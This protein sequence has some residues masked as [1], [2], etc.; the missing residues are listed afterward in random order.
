MAGMTDKSGHKA[1][2]TAVVAALHRELGIPASYAIERNLVAHDE[3]R[4]A[5]LVEVGLNPDGRPVRLT[6]RAVEAWSRMRD[7]ATADGIQL[8]PISGFRPVARQAE[9]IREKRAAGQSLEDILRYVAAPGFSEHTPAARSTS[10]RPSTSSWTKISNTRQRSSG[11][12]S[13]RAN[14][15]SRFPIRAAMRT[16]LATSHG[17]GAGAARAP[18]ADLAP[19]KVCRA[20]LAAYLE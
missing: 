16:A 17:T 8:V 20:S 13:T 7:A 2:P 11:S 10:A 3:A 15:A 5:D 18:A 6:A 19:R 14:S 1:P 12:R 4:E 9:I